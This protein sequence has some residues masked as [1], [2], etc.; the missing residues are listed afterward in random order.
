MQDALLE[1]A[2]P[3]STQTETRDGVTL[4]SY[5]GNLI[6]RPGFT[7]EI[8]RPTRDCCCADTS[9]PR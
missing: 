1:Y 5:R 4:L 7:P 6:N 3:R 8:V 9:A 2:K